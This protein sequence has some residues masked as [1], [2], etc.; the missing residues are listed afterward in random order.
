MNKKIHL[1]YTTYSYYAHLKTTS[2]H[3]TLSSAFLIVFLVTL[4]PLAM[5]LPVHLEQ[6]LQ[7]GSKQQ[8]GCMRQVKEGKFTMRTT[9]SARYPRWGGSPQEGQ[10][11][12]RCRPPWRCGPAHA[13]RRATLHQAG[14][15]QDLLGQQGH[16]LG[17]RWSAAGGM[18]LPWEPGCW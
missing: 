12:E 1:C 11:G 16:P 18:G 14:P 7:F 15:G 8:A 5:S 6:V 17:C 4:S 2:S 9:H 13:W 3:R 10:V